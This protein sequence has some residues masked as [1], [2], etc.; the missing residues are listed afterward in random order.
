M[1][2]YESFWHCY[3]TIPAKIVITVIIVITPIT[4]AIMDLSHYVFNERFTIS[5]IFAV[6]GGNSERDPLLCT[7]DIVGNQLASEMGGIGTEIHGNCHNLWK[8][9]LE[10]PLKITMILETRLS[11]ALVKCILKLYYK[12]GNFCKVSGVKFICHSYVFCCNN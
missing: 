9:Q 10:E 11:F 5:P 1:R 7:I 6:G 12:N 3:K 8:I 2:Q 4:V